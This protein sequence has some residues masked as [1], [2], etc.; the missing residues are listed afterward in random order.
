MLKK[1]LVAAFASAF[2]FAVYTPSASACGD[3]ETK[4]VAKEKKKD[5]DKSKKT[6]KKKKSSKKKPG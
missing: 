4:K 2:A 1:L 5:A 6:A 3:M